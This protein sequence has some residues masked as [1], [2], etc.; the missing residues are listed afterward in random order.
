MSTKDVRHLFVGACHFGSVLRSSVLYADVVRLSS[1]L[2]AMKNASGNFTQD[3][4]D[5]NN[6]IYANRINV[7]WIISNVLCTALFTVTSFDTHFLLTMICMHVD[8]WIGMGMIV[9]ICMSI[10]MHLSPLIIKLINS[11]HHTPIA[12]P[13]PSPGIFPYLG[14]V[15]G[16]AVMTPVFEIFIRFVSMLYPHHD[17]LGPFFLQKKSACLLSH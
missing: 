9:Y 10:F 15:G 14:M 4:P 13:P 5:P 12:S 8:V 3:G 7:R 1:H 11:R 17:L 2:F 6:I 16:C